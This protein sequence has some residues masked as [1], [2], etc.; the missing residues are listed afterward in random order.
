[1][2]WCKARIF[3]I[4]PYIRC[5]TRKLSDI[6]KFE[7]KDLRT[8]RVASVFP[9]LRP[10]AWELKGECEGP[11]TNWEDLESEIRC[12]N[13]GEDGSSSSERENLL[14]YLFVLS[15]SSTD[16]MVSQWWGWIFTQST[17]SCASVFQKHPYRF[18]VLPPIQAS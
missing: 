17:H 1:M 14:S 15:R 9:S 8:S 11:V 18:H 6:I 10:M 4:M 12:P 2:Q 3:H 16:W 5:R 7:F 13:T